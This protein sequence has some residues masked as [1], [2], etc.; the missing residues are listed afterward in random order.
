MGL[1]LD[2][3]TRFVQS[4]LGHVGREYPHALQHVMAGSEEITPV[5]LHP[6]FY[7]SFD[8]HSCVH[9][10]WQLF[11]LARLFPELAP[12][13]Y[14]CAEATFTRENVV[15]ELGYLRRQP[16][17]ERPYGWGWLLALHREI[18]APWA[19]TLEPLAALVAERFKAYLPKLMFPVRAGTH[20]NTA[21]AL[22][23]ALEW[24]DDHDGD[25]AD[26]IRDWARSRFKD[27]RN[28][29]HQEP[30]GEDFLSPS[31]TEAQLLAKSLPDNEFRA[32]LD[33]FMPVLPPNLLSPVVVLDRTD[34]RIGHLDGLNLSR[35]WGWRSLAPYLPPSAQESAARHLEAALPH[36]AENYMG[37]HWLATFA[38]LALSVD[39]N[40]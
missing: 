34:G 29:A 15:G 33:E 5:R 8:W 21:F 14:A 18:P 38:L 10:W 37:E 7:G 13:I 19:A 40:S 16:W 27:D 17:F 3:A 4:T 35:A 39:A 30:S 28:A 12:E 11:R 9:A 6:I 31:L 25:L 1:D 26:Q 2:L 23:L 22:I 20:S 32:W 24:A 36:V